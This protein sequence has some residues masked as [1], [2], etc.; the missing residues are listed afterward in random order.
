MLSARGG[1]QISLSITGSTYTGCLALSVSVLKPDG[2]TLGSTGL[3]SSTGFIDSMTM[4]VTGTYTVLVNPA[5]ANTGAV[6]LQINTFTD[7]SGTITIGTPLSVTTTGIG[8][9]ARYT[10]S[11]TAAQQ[12]SLTL[13]SSTYTGCTALS[14]SVLKPDGS[15]LGSTGLCS[16]S[17]LIS[18]MTLPVTGTYT[19]FIDP[20]GTS[21]GSVIA[22]I[23]MFGD[24]SGSITIGTPVTV[25]TTVVGQKA[26]LVFSGTVGQQITLS[27]TSSTF[28]GCTALSALVLKPDGSTLGSTGLCSST[29]FIDSM[30]MP[31][32]GAYTVL[33]TPGGT[34]VGSV[35]VQLNTFTDISG[36]ITIG[37][38]LS[39]TTTGIG[40]NARYT[41][42]GTTGQQ[43][44][45]S[46]AGSTYTG[47]TALSVSVLKPDGSTLGSTGLCSST[48][49]ID[50]MTMPVTGTY[51]VLVNPAGANTGSVTLQINT[52]TDISGTITIGTPLTATTTG[53]GQNARYTFSGTTGQKISVSISGSTYTGCTALSVAILKPDG[54]TLA[55]TGLCSSTGSIAATTLPVT[56]AY[57]LLID[58][59]GANTGSVTA[60]LA[61]N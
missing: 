44:S 58:P 20:G 8:Q 55:S 14:V 15:T 9:N 19:V 6:T 4:P 13:S 50:S 36:T 28:T 46:I 56:G 5:G 18:S 11:G 10:F 21:T 49:F 23:S 17:G 61:L 31:S 25:T 26:R 39:V 3:C 53:I 60:A 16:S 27:L 24:I 40:Q 35:T 43:I 38:P 29:G 51:T 34:A 22:L 47:C 42:S 12:I 7:I 37:T 33:L 32:T 41:F 30:T 2:S 48:G 52:F 45:L 54:S 59:A 1:Q 57:T